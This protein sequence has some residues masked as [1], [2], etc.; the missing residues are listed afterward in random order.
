MA[1]IPA[2]AAP[3]TP[4]AGGA[5]PPA[6]PPPAGGGSGG[7]GGGAAPVPAGGGGGGA[8]P[9]AGSRYLEREVQRDGKTVKERVREEAL[10]N[11]HA[12]EGAL[13]RK[14][15]ETTKRERELE[16]QAQALAQREERFKKGNI[17]DL[18][19]DRQG[20]EHPIALLAR[21][22]EELMKEEEQSQ[23][24]RMRQLLN[25]SR[26]NDKLRAELDGIKT[27][28]Q[29]QAF[30]QAVEAELEK[31]SAEFVPALQLMKL[32]KNDITMRLMAEAK[33]TAQQRGLPLDASALARETHKAAAGM[34]EGLV[35]GIEDDEE[36]VDMFPKFSR[37]LHAGLLK[38]HRRLTES[39]QAPRIA[40][41]KPTEKPPEKSA[42]GPKL[43]RS[44]DEDK[45]YFGN[46][47]VLRSGI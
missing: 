13:N 22:L 12:R 46:R 4:A 9:A 15:E 38:R 20:D 36:L 1:D 26:E 18:L 42:E 14:F 32:P 7:S 24:P 33:E 28:E 5:P 41:P 37:R 2:G 31:L 43:V 39:N 27:R 19:K 11:A 29:K 47:K 16:A 17:R 40:P 44:V 25:K 23:D 21:E 34:V 6:A 8:P 3:S 10:W 30:D 45:A 35:E